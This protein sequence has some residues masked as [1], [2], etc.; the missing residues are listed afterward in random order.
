MR[1]GCSV[2]MHCTSVHGKFC[3]YKLK[4]GLWKNRILAAYVRS[5]SPRYSRAGLLRAFGVGETSGVNLQG[6][7][8]GTN[9]RHDTISTPP[10]LNGCVLRINSARI[11][12]HRHSSM[13]SS[14]NGLIVSTYLICRRSMLAPRLRVGRCRRV[15]IDAGFPRSK[16][17]CRSVPA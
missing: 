13:R 5:R 12:H 4:S 2:F 9:I 8:A 16:T 15:G 6:F 1:T 10:E 3:D 14:A 11:F 17:R 7:L